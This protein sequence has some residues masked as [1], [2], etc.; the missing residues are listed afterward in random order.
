MLENNFTSHSMTPDYD[1]LTVSN[2]KL[3]GAEI[4]ISGIKLPTQIFFS[5]VFDTKKGT[6]T[7][8]R[9]L[10]YGGH[11]FKI[12]IKWD[13]DQDYWTINCSMWNETGWAMIV[14]KDALAFYS[15]KCSTLPGKV[16]NPKMKEAVNEDMD[17][18]EEH[19]IKI[20]ISFL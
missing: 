14:D 17:N 9:M 16:D 5:R 10:S 3:P 2:H 6:V 8:F 11:K 18:L 1:N 20:V 19:I 12:F 13:K 7:S 4:R 15:P